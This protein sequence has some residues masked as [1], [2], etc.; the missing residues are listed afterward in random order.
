MALELAAQVPTPFPFCL[1]LIQRS[2]MDVQRSFLWSFLWGDAA[3]PTPSPT[4]T[5]T[6]TLIPAFTKVTGDVG[7]TAAWSAIGLVNPI[8]TQQFRV[9][10]GTLYNIIAYDPPLSPNNPGAFGILTLDRPYVDPTAGVG[11]G[12]QIVGA[13]YNAPC[14]D[15]LWWESVTDPISGYTLRTCVT[16]E[17]SYEVDPQRFQSGWPTA[18]LPYRINPFKGSFYNFPQYEIWPTPLNHYTYI[19]QYYRSGTPFVNYGDTVPSPMGEDIIIALGK[20]YAYQWCEA[21]KDKL[22][23]E[24]RKGDYRFLMGGAKKEYDVLLDKYQMKD[25]EFSH[26][27]VI[28]HGDTPYLE[29]LPWVSARENVMYAP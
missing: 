27:H 22:Q 10:Q 9:G 1:T 6:V 29:L 26:R 5:G 20:Y 19:G 12:Y 11:V 4:Q 7:A 14:I 8:T 13:Y 24:Q 21:N 2:W 18:V 25:E 28:A 16:R 15:F 3:I 17:E 23:P